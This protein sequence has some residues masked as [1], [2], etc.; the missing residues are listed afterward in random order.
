M[1]KILVNIYFIVG[2]ILFLLLFLWFGESFIDFLPSFHDTPDMTSLVIRQGIFAIISLILCFL[3]VILFFL[4]NSEALKNYFKS[5]TKEEK[6]A[7]KHQKEE[8]EKQRKIQSLQ[9]Q[10]DDLKN[11]KDGK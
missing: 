5:K 3:S 7:E 4:V 2:S 1:K 9:K 11:T 6:Q 10:I 8:A